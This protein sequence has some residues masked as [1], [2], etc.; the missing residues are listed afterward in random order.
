MAPLIQKPI[1]VNRIF[2]FSRNVA[3]LPLD[4]LHGKVQKKILLARLLSD[5][6]PG[7]F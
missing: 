4:Y 7:L 2:V 6:Q 5:T 3:M 1:E